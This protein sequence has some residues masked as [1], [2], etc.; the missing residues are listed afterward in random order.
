MSAPSSIEHP[1]TAEGLIQGNDKGYGREHVGK[2]E[3]EEHL[4][5]SRETEARESIGRQRSQKNT[6]HGDEESHV[7]AVRHDCA[8]LALRTRREENPAIAGKI[9]VLRNPAQ[10]YGQKLFQ[11]GDAGDKKP[12]RGSKNHQ[13]QKDRKNRDHQLIQ[14]CGSL[15]RFTPQYSIWRRMLLV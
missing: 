7:E 12:E 13:G 15:H 10:G 6:D 8:K 5:F 9:R 1:Q 11:I 14:E 4:V 3:H 2:K